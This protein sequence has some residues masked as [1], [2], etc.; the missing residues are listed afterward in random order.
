M[1]GETQVVI[2]RDTDSKQT[3]GN[4]HRC[5]SKESVGRTHWVSYNL[6]FQTTVI[7]SRGWKRNVVLVFEFGWR[8]LRV[9]KAGAFEQ[10]SA[11][12]MGLEVRWEAGLPLIHVFPQTS[13]SHCSLG[14]LSKNARIWEMYRFSSLQS[15]TGPEKVLK[16][17]L[18]NKENWIFS[19]E[20]NK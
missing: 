8:L 19:K 9:T 2:Q 17:P 1:S 11:L 5:R 13:A 16:C 3:M 15:C 14:N 20:I 7:P 6:E 18:G 10:S 12:Q 4:W